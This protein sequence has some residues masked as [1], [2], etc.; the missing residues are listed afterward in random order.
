[1]GVSYESYYSAGILVLGVFAGSSLWWLILSSAVGAVR[2]NLNPKSLR[3]VNRISAAIILG[4]GIVALAGL[5][6]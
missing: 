2:D 4:F 1:L 5:V 3:W 6:W